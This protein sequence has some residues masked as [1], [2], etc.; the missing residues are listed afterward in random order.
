MKN[1]RRRPDFYETKC[2]AG[3][4]YQ[5]KAAQADFF[6]Q[7]LMVLCPVNAVCNLFSTNHSS[8][9]LAGLFYVCFTHCTYG[10]LSLTC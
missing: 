4:T 1:M 9:S 8:E 3:K 7:V 6:D 10:I 2:A 5:K